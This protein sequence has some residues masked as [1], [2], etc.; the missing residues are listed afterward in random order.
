MFNC[1]GLRFS[2][3]IFSPSSEYSTRFA[4]KSVD[5]TY[6]LQLI[7]STGGIGVA[8]ALWLYTFGSVTSTGCFAGVSVSTATNYADIPAAWK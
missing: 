6:A 5:F 1:S 7:G 3:D 2:S 8:P 4:G